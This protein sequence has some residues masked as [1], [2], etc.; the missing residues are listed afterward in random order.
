MGDEGGSGRRIKNDGDVSADRFMALLSYSAPSAAIPIIR[1]W[2]RRVSVSPCGAL[3]GVF[4][5]VL[6]IN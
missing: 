4:P 3:V 1:R 2:N 6:V 5:H